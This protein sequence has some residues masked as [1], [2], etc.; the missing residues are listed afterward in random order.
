MQ[1]RSFTEKGDVLVTVMHVDGNIDSSTYEAFESMADELIKGGRAVPP[2]DCNEGPR[3]RFPSTL[4]FNAA[5]ANLDLWVRKGLSPPHGE[6]IT[7]K[8]GKPVLDDFGNVSG[9]VRSPFVDVPTSTW[10]GNSTGPSFCRIAGHERRFD[11]AQLKSLYPT[12][13]DYVNAV[14]KNVRALVD[15]RFIVKEDGDALIAAAKDAAVP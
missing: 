5:L 7:V 2:M 3:S 9:G 11:A 6:A 13:A 10:N 4:A 12:H 1:I 15:A 14:T 8:D